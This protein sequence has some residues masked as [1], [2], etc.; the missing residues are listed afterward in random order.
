[1]TVCSGDGGC[2]GS[3]KQGL[4]ANG[5]ATLNEILQLLLSN[6]F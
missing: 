2:D 4:L 5:T 3:F 6:Q 1:M